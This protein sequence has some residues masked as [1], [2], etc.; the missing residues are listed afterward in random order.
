MLSIWGSLLRGQTETSL[1]EELKTHP[2]G[3]AAWPSQ[4]E[5]L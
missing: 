4:L 1:K 3:R 2:P 5:G